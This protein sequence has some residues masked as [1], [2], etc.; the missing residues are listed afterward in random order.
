MFSIFG[1]G[2]QNRQG[3]HR[4]ATSNLYNWESLEKI[5][6]FKINMSHFHNQQK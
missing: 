4:P 6:T 3:N 5:Q 2:N 1:R